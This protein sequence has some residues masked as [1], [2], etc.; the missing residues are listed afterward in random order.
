MGTQ[1]MK[2]LTYLCLVFVMLVSGVYGVKT[3]EIE[4]VRLRTDG[5]TTDLTASDV[6][7]IK[8]FW[9]NAL[10]T[11]QLTE[12]VQEIVL[13]RRQVE[14]QKSVQ[15]LCSYAAAYIDAAAQYLPQ[16]LV[17]IDSV[18]DSARRQLLEQNLMILTAML[19]SPKLASIAL[20]RI[21]REESGC[22]L[23]GG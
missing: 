8:S 3:T 16:A 22:A 13:I 7:V 19:E 11:I 10:S 12:D 6:S 15:P 18:A 2:N 17:Q 9:Q 5:S 23:L 20:A 1:K 4:A 14:A 21:D